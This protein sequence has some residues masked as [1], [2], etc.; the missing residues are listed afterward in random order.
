MKSLLLFLARRIGGMARVFSRCQ[1]FLGEVQ[2]HLLTTAMAHGWKPTEEEL[3]WLQQR[4][5]KVFMKRMDRK[6]AKL[7]KKASK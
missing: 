7:N 3:N 4:Q 1:S 2:T 5:Y 6:R